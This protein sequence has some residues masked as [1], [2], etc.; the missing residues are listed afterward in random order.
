MAG[1]LVMIVDD[2]D[3]NLKLLRDVLHFEGYRTVEARTGAAALAL[4]ADQPPDVVLMDIG[5]PDQSGLEALRGLRA[6]PGTRTTP[7]LAVTASAMVG[8]RERFIAAGFDDYLAKPIR[9]RELVERVRRLCERS[10]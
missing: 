1:Q 5:L 9:T 8:D 7:V 3:L 4:A 6:D 10:T 2:N